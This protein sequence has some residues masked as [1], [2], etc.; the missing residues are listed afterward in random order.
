LILIAIWTAVLVPSWIQSRREMTPAR[1]MVTFQKRMTSLERTAPHY[2]A[3]SDDMYL[4]ASYVDRS[5]DS[6]GGELGGDVEGVEVTGPGQT[7]VA[8]FR[9]RPEAIAETPVAPTLRA[10]SRM[11]LQRRRQIFFGLVLTWVV[12]LALAAVTESLAVLAA[13][14]VASLLLFTYIGLLVLHHKRALEHAA[15]VRY[16]SPAREPRPAVVVLR[17]GAAR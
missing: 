13:N 7:A 14:G 9:P 15:K 10:G 8:Q 6:V 3:Y 16:L 5:D 4:D 11:A 17:S 1:S 2:E 12:S